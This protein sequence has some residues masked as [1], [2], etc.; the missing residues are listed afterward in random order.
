MLVQV[1]GTVFRLMETHEER[2]MSTSDTRDVPLFGFR[3]DVGLDPVRVDVA[4]MI[5]HYRRGAA[6]LM[7]LWHLVF[8]P[9]DSAHLSAAAASDDAAFRIDDD[10]WARLVF[11][12]A[13]AFH[14]RVMDRDSLLLAALPL[15]MGRVASFVNETLNAPASDVDAVIERLCRSFER[16]KDY[17]RHRWREPPR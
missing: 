5:D 17:L 14:H 2:W 13:S 4:R 3:Y 15:Y 6:E 7:D 16:Q 9:A 8:Q 10:L 11:D 1:L 12:L